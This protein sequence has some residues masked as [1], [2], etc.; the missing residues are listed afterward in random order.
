MMG[1]KY[2]NMRK[3]AQIGATL[4]WVGAFLIIFF[5][6][7]LFGSFTA[8]LAGEKV[9]TLNEND[10]S[11]VSEKK[12][13]ENQK[14]LRSILESTLDSNGQEIRE[15]IIVW[16]SLKDEKRKSLEVEIESKVSSLLDSRVGRDDCYSFKAVQ[17]PSEFGES[18][19]NSYQRPEDILDRLKL[20]INLY[21]LENKIKLEFYIGEC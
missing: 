19:I 5:I 4:T 17:S 6:M 9:V 13:F 3:K 20:R 7:I 21:S 10:I 15:A 2:F 18:T 14:Q 8:I 16:S 1:K 11:F 12:G